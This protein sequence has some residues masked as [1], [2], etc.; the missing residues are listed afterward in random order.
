MIMYDFKVS[1][2]TIKYYT[3]LNIISSLGG[4]YAG[5]NSIMGKMGTLFTFQFFWL[6][7]GTVKRL[8]GHYIVKKEI[9]KNVNKLN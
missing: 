6:F 3:I 4:I 5:I 2:T 7:G 1:T 9:Q 8:A